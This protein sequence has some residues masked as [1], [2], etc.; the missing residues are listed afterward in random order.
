MCPLLQI[1]VFRTDHGTTQFNGLNHESVSHSGLKLE[2]PLIHSSLSY[3]SRQYLKDVND[4]FKASQIKLLLLFS[5]S[6]TWDKAQI[7]L[8]YYNSFQTLAHPSYVILPK[9][10][11]NTIFIDIWNTSK[12]YSFVSSH[13]KRVIKCTNTVRKARE[14]IIVLIIWILIVSNI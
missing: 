1:S 8:Y 2:K 12:F 5:T 11:M 4:L 13:Q 6:I 3:I 10:F 9:T 7:S 14:K